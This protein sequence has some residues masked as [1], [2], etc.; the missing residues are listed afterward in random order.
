MSLKDTQWLFKCT[1]TQKCW[2]YVESSKIGPS[3][4]FLNYFCI[5]LSFLRSQKTHYIAGTN[6]T[7]WF[8][9]IWVPNNETNP[10]FFLKN[11]GANNLNMHSFNWLP[12]ITKIV[13]YGLNT[14]LLLQLLKCFIWHLAWCLNNFDCCKQSLKWL[15]HP[16]TNSGLDFFSSFYYLITNVQ[17]SPPFF[18][19]L[20]SQWNGS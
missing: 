7:T 16:P 11:L 1:F 4:P 6:Q 17:L 5:V 9:W 12:I 14:K 20:P 8:N 15:S 19:T 10:E 3:S 2:M 18:K 13:V